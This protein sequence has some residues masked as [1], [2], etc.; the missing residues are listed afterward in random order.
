MKQKPKYLVNVMTLYQTLFYWALVLLWGGTLIW[1]WTWWLQSTHVVTVVGL[2]ITSY[3]AAYQTI[4]PGW[5]YWFAGRAKKPNMNL[6]FPKG[7]VAI[8]T[9]KVPSEPNEMMYH[10][11]SAMLAQKYP[12]RFDVWLAAEESRQDNPALYAWCETHHVGVTCRKGI[13]EFNRKTYP[14]QAKTKEGNTLSWYEM[15]GYKNY[16][17]VVQL[18]ADHS[19]A[20]SDY[21]HQM[22]APFINPKVGLVAAPSMNDANYDE[23]WAVR[24]RVNAETTF[25]GLMQAGYAADGCAMGIGSHYAVRTAALKAAGG[26]GPTRAEDASTTLFINVAGY[27]SVFSMDALAHGEGPGSFGAV[28]TQEVD[29]SSSLTRILL[30]WM[31]KVFHKLP[32]RKKIIFLFS[33]GWYPLYGS[34]MLVGIILPTIAMLT[35]TPW[36]S[37]NYLDFLWRWWMLIIC[38]ILPIWFIKAHGWFRPSNAP[39]IS[40]E[41]IA[42]QMVRWPWVVIGCIWGA[43]GALFKTSYTFHITPKGAN[44]ERPLGFT[45]IVPYLGIVLLVGWAIMMI[46]SA[47]KAEGYRFLALL[48]VAMYTAALLI[49]VL[50]HYKEVG[51][52]RSRLSG[53]PGVLG[54]IVSIVLVLVATLSA[55]PKLEPVFAENKVVQATPDSQFTYVGM[56]SVNILGPTPTPTPQPNIVQIIAAVFAPSPTPLPIVELPAGR[57]LTGI[58]DPSGSFNDVHFDIKHSFTDWNDPSEISNAITAAQQVGEF[59]MVTVQPIP[60]Q[61]LNPL[62]LLQDIAAGKYD[63]TI[64]AMATTIYRFAPQKVIVRWGHE[65]DV[66][67]AYEWSTCVPGNFIP[68]YRHVIDLIRAQGVTNIIWMWSPAGNNNAEQ[69]WPGNGY[70]DLIGVTDL[71]SEDWDRDFNNS[72]PWPQPMN[73]LFYLRYRLAVEYN[74][75]IIMTELGVAYS[76]PNVN[77]TQWFTDGFRSVTQQKYPL[78]IGWVYFNDVGQMNGHVLILPDF[79]VTREELLTGLAAGG[80]K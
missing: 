14:G 15:V 76:D 52:L 12:G 36:M 45:S 20:N 40:W 4:I 30:E 77:K 10:T 59:P 1:F 22:I 9:T 23:S 33:Q 28:A 46:G 55:F 54:S 43:I 80:Y 78:L 70:V 51:D 16:D 44:K 24:G 69:F 37:M 34:I 27:D 48:D 8:M 31:P 67:G 21:L 63:D 73:Q 26:P 57:I 50:R 62:S 7:R 35:K 19:P 75:P 2:L 11:L 42:F 79:R 61:N 74:K 3:V 18:D 13:P 72:K 29:W 6:P 41:A 58:Y 60:K 32:L 39:L 25:H 5:F 17:Y 68:A 47:G 65:M 64:K 49:I 53:I 66:C 56:R 38:C 71:S